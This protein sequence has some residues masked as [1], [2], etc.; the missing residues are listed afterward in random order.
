MRNKGTAPA[1]CVSV[2]LLQQL[3]A[4]SDGQDSKCCIV[5]PDQHLITSMIFLV[6]ASLQ[7]LFSARI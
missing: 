7:L 4:R 5:C 3:G 1:W 2:R 6:V